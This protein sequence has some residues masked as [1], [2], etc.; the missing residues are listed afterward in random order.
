MINA[1]EECCKSWH[2]TSALFCVK[3]AQKRCGIFDYSLD[4]SFTGTTSALCVGDHEHAKNETVTT[5]RGRIEL[6][7]LLTLNRRFPGCRRSRSPFTSVRFRGN[8]LVIRLTSPPGN[9]HEGSLLRRRFRPFGGRA[10]E[11][12]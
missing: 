10:Y 3:S 1:D 9:C 7:D 4:R 6:P 2:D 12:P 8:V 5:L 11:P